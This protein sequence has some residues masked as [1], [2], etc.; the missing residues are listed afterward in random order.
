MKETFLH[1][2]FETRILGKSFQ[3]TNGDSL[4]V[5]SFGKLNKSS[6]PDFLEASLRLQN[7][8]WA[9]NIEFHV[10]SSDWLKHGHQNDEA[11]NN[12]I[13][14]FV[15][16]HDVEIYSGEYLLPVVELKEN[17][18]S[19]NIDKGKN[20]QVNK[21]QL[22]CEKSFPNVDL[23]VVKNQLEL[24][25]DQRLKRKRDEVIKLMRLHANDQKRVMLILIAKSLG[26]K[27]NSSPMEALISKID[28]TTLS[29]LTDSFSHT[30]SYTLGLS[31]IESDEKFKYLKELYQLH[32]MSKVE[33]KTYGMR[34]PSQPKY[35]LLQLAAILHEF[36]MIDLYAD[37]KQ[38]RAYFNFP[39]AEN[40][41]ALSDNYFNLILINAIVP[42]LEA[43]S[44]FKG[45]EILSKKARELLID[46]KPEN[47]SIIQEWIRL[48]LKPENAKESQALIELKNQYCN[49]KKCLIC[50]IGKSVLEQ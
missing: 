44:W 1:Y 7:K 31:G 4:E 42:F 49:E 15:Y 19:R 28:F 21:S 29:R 23:E 50:G 8:I 20:F 17:I 32:S 38:W 13:A 24:A 47:N 39:E 14:H 37:K 40:V 3:T 18:K 43:I 34:P 16:E 2:L 35:R 45:D 9:G 26:G 33:W 10:K 30:R 25:L 5:L 27:Y 36:E 48:G 11:Y 6:G 12:V 46:L 41:P 22:L